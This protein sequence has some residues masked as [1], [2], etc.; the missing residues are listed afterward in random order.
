MTTILD[1]TL[2]TATLIVA[3]A[4]I[5]SLTTLA[6]SKAAEKTT[7]VNIVKYPDGSWFVPEGSGLG[8]AYGQI[9]AFVGYDG[10]VCLTVLK[11]GSAPH[12][13]ASMDEIAGLHCVPNAAK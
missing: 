9:K 13:V 11:D 8:P 10:T 1:R 4:A 12:A 5:G 6:R 3:G 7:V 2:M